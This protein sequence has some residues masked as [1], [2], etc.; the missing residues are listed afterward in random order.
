[1]TAVIR[2]E[3]QGAELVARRIQE[4]VQAA[5]VRLGMR[6]REVHVTLAYSS[7]TFPLNAQ[8]ER[9]PASSPLAE[10]PVMAAKEHHVG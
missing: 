6:G 1:M 3:H 9:A 10:G 2:A 4:I 5:P 7:L 8:N